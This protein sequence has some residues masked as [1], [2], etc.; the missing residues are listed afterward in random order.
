MDGTLYQTQ[1]TFPPMRFRAVLVLVAL[2]TMSMTGPMFAK[3]IPPGAIEAYNRGI[4]EINQGRVD[5]AIGAFSKA[6]ELA[7]HFGQAFADRGLAYAV[8]EDFSRAI[9]DLDTA[10]ELDPTDIASLLDRGYAHFANEQLDLAVADY[11]AVL[12][13]A[14]HS[15]DGYR[16]RGFVHA[17]Q[18]NLDRAVNDLSHALHLAPRDA[19]AFTSRAITYSRKG[20]L[21]RAIADYSQALRLNP[22][23]AQAWS[24]RGYARAMSGDTRRAIDDLSYAIRLDPDDPANWF[25]RGVAYAKSEDFGKAI[26]DFDR[27]LQLDPTYAEVYREQA[28][29]LSTEGRLDQALARATRSVELAKNDPASHV[30]RGAI[31]ARM[32]TAN[33]TM[34]DKAMADFNEAIRLNPQEARA[35]F[36]RALSHADRGNTADA[37][38]DYRALVRLDASKPETYRQWARRT[39][40]PKAEA[41]VDAF[42]AQLTAEQNRAWPRFAEGSAQHERG[43]LNAALASYTEVVRLA[44]RYATAYYNRAI[45]HAEAGDL[46]KAAADYGQIIRLDSMHVSAHINRGLLHYQRG[47]FHAADDDFARAEQLDTDNPKVRTMRAAIEDALKRP[48]H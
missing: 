45:V 38:D 6:I 9:A 31:L 19:A 23:D 30:G 22:L 4:A 37:L 21:D 48:E 33:P 16:E 39:Q 35:Y 25:S 11:D 29:A 5:E 8:K 27:A 14:P 3:E 10:I 20:D 2:L 7:P 44:P 32:G 24:D 40:S 47:W 41:A 12:R 28:R 36:H 26:T 17:M 34:G 18:G 46:S 43:D 42:E 1:L 13:I 15:A